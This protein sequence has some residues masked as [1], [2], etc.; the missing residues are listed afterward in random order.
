[1]PKNNCIT[2]T[3]THNLDFRTP[4]DLTKV[5]RWVIKYATL[6]V[7][8]TEETEEPLVYRAL[9]DGCHDWK[10]SDEQEVVNEEDIGFDV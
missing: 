4:H 7:W 2:A 10:W 3:Y 8:L 5:H 1:M 9:N 6:S